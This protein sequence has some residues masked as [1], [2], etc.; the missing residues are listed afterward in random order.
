MQ[1]RILVVD[2]EQDNCDYLKLVLTREGYEV[3]TT[4]DPTKTVEMLRAA[5]YHLVVL[6]MM[7]PQM[8]GTEVLEQIRKIDS[9]VAVIVATAYPNVDTAVAS[10][11]A[12][13][14]DYVKKPMEPEQFLA[15]VRSALSKKGLSQ[16]PEADLHRAIGRTIREA[17]KTQELTLKQ[18][19]RRTGLS[20]SLLSQIERA[21][22]SAS[23]SSLYKIAS[24]LQIKMGD[25][26]GGA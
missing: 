24:A 17:R 6:D 1:I 14:S 22:S 25:L 10:L 26:F 18:L 19:A 21:E 8:S 20:V 9:D 13:A 23:I 5:D 3:A 12:Q 4:T 16:D 15:A 7:M 11:K 2:D